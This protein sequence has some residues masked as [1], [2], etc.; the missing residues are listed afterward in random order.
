MVRAVRFDTPGVGTAGH[1]GDTPEAVE[2]IRALTGTGNQQIGPHANDA[3][4]P[5]G[6]AL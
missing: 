2:Q 1:T 6:Q 5:A 3:G 4:P